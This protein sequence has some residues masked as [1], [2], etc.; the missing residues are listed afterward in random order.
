MDMARPAAAGVAEVATA[1]SVST[2]ASP[3]AAVLREVLARIDSPSVAPVL[4]LGVAEIPSPVL[5]IASS[6]GLRT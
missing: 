3:V 1:P 6:A 2:T 5:G 4:S